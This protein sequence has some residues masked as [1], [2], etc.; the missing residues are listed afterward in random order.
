MQV[1]QN[2]RT[3][4]ELDAQHTVRPS[5]NS[6]ER[7]PQVGE[8]FELQLQHNLLASDVLDRQTAYSK[9]T[10]SL[11]FSSTSS[12]RWVRVHKGTCRAVGAA[13]GAVGDDPAGAA[14][15]VAPNP[16]AA[17]VLA[18]AFAEVALLGAPCSRR[19]PGLPISGYVATLNF[20]LY[21]GCRFAG[22][23]RGRAVS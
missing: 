19:P 12:A 23:R 4:S 17:T 1:G 6:V 16:L 10:Y 13:G 2:R 5:A 21:V 15:W 9:S 22:G 20:L 8:E 7:T 3:L 14:A 11:P 18:V